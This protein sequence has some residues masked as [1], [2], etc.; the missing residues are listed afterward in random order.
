M[1][2]KPTGK[3]VFRAVR[4]PGGSRVAPARH[5]QRKHDTARVRDVLHADETTCK[6]YMH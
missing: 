4:P 5:G 2:A 3:A 6:L 1:M